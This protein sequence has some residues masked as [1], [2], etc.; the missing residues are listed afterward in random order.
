MASVLGPA[1]AAR[2]PII[3][4]LGATGTGKS[5][6]ALELATRFKGEIISAD[7][8]QVYKGLDIITNKVTP[9]EAA[10]APHHILG[11]LDPLSRF[12]VT[13]FRNAA[14]PVVERL[15]AEDKVPVI[16]GGTNYYIESL[17]WH[18]L[19]DG[20]PK[21]SDGKLVYERDKEL[22]SGGGGSG[23]KKRDSVVSGDG[24]F[25]SK[26]SRVSDDDVG[27]E[28]GRNVTTHHRNAENG[29]RVTG[30]SESE[31][32]ETDEG[33]DHDQE[34]EESVR[35]SGGDG[36]ESGVQESDIKSG[37]RVLSD[38]GE[39]GVRKSDI[40]SDDG[41]LSDG[42]E[43]VAHKSDVKSGGD[44]VL[45]DK[46]SGDD[47]GESGVR[48]SGD[49]VLSEK[50]CGGDIGGD[51]G[52]GL[53]VW[54]ETD[55]PTQELYQRLRQVDPEIADTY[56]PNERRKII[57]SLQVYE[58]TGRPHSYL[59]KE[60]R[61]QKGGSGLGGALRYPHSLILWITCDQDVLLKR[62]DDRVDEMI[63]RGLLQELLDFHASYNSRRLQDGAAADY[64]CGIFQSIG[65]K[66]FHEFLVLPEEERESEK[67]LKLY[68]A[69]VAAMKLATRQYTKKQLRW[70]KNRFITPSDRKVRAQ[71][72]WWWW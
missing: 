45:S 58:Q 41:V 42:G 13:D 38:G 68:E 69:G 71:K 34:N 43:S 20:V 61:G 21:G 1:R 18:V 6:L 56:H 16:V 19:I 60:Q 37:D 59:L 49:G 7:S 15:L 33:K 72:R 50:D 12:T 22:Y 48:E 47:G 10:Q 11:F 24:F 31:G 17:L 40:K 26:R 54:Q 62:L 2:L 29:E 35:V 9:E 46:D 27:G 64:T 14:L 53:T 32:K 44:G 57:R 5:K 67:G 51:I 3:V 70:I 30:R 65:F 25:A 4:V 52:G 28:G 39:S 23:E 8:M 63:E 36:D 66:E 55:T